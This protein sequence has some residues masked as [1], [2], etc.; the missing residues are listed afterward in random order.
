M[1]KHVAISESD[2]SVIHMQLLQRDMFQHPVEQ[3]VVIN[4]QTKFLGSFTEH[5]H[6]VVQKSNGGEGNRA[7]HL[8]RVRVDDA[9]VADAV[10]AAHDDLL[11]VLADHAE[12]LRGRVLCAE[13]HEELLHVAQQL[14]R[15]ALACRVDADLDLRRREEHRR[16]ELRDADRL[17]EAPG[18]G[19]LWGRR[20]SFT[21][22]EQTS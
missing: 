18:R 16:R 13:Q 22:R 10:G 2:L 9:H 4:I 6:R 12:A 1:Q 20:V 3:Y 11:H 14:L 17:A 7:A 21:Y 8:A 19:D 15:D 5:I